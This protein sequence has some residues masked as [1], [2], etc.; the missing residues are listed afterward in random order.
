[1]KSIKEKNA[2]KWLLEQQE[3]LAEYE[4]SMLFSGL[5]SGLDKA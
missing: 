2:V 1:M 4:L 5:M 3:A